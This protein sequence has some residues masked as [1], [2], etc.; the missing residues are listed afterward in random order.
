[1]DSFKSLLSNAYSV[2]GNK[3]V[4]TVSVSQDFIENMT[5]IIKELDFLPYDIWVRAMNSLG[6]SEAS[7][8]VTFQPI[9]KPVIKSKSRLLLFLSK[10]LHFNFLVMGICFPNFNLQ[11]NTFTSIL[12]I[13]CYKFRVRC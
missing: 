10:L 11:V 7:D 8:V 1:M 2:L 9:R 6:T 12:A 13:Y 3:T 4:Q 5:V